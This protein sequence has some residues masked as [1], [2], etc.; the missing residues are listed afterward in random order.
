M[1]EAQRAIRI[2]GGLINAIQD[3]IDGHFHLIGFIQVKEANWQKSFT[4][5]ALHSLNQWVGKADS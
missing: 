1:D 5:K 2:T 4:G 3:P